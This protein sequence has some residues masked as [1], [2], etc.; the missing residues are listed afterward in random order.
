V[1]LGCSSWSY[2]KAIQDGRLD[3][4]RWLRLCAEELDLDG[5]E[6]LDLH[7]PSTDHDYLRDLKR[8][9]T[10][11]HLTISCV[12][13][14][15]DFGVI[16]REARRA[17]VA[18][19]KQ[20]VEIASYLGA[21]V[22][23]VFAGWVPR[24]GAAKPEQAGFLVRLRRLFL[25]PDVR[26]EGWPEVI[27]CLREC[28]E[29]A[30]ERGIVLGL[31][32]HNGRGFVGTADD[33]ERCLHDVGSAWLRLCL[34][35]G[36]YGDLE[37]IDRTLRHAVHLHAKLYDL[38]GDGVERKLDWPSIMQILSKGRYRGFL[39]IEYEGEEDAVAALARGVPYLRRLMAPGELGSRK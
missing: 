38:D 8:R 27:A 34:D 12:S 1:K 14:S 9:C 5:V 29:F 19:V 31:E 32:N 6:L 39:S 4:M 10:D 25:E 18:K 7:F 28:A 30:Q 33:V 26:R 2:H 3:Q 13:V 16:D 15:N 35:T 11:L 36:D 23:R 24:E 37:S 20:W 22:L 17:E 21:P